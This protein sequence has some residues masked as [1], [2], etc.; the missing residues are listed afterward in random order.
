MV[1]VGNIYLS[2]NENYLLHFS[3]SQQNAFLYPA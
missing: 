2:R 1:Q 3:N